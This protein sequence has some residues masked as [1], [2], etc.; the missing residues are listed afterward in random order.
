[1]PEL[2]TPLPSEWLDAFTL[3]GSFGPWIDVSSNLWYMPNPFGLPRFPRCMTLDTSISHS[4]E[5]V[6]KF[7]P[8]TALLECVNILLD[9]F[10]PVCIYIHPG[11]NLPFR[12]LSQILQVLPTTNHLNFLPYSAFHFQQHVKWPLALCLE[13]A[14]FCYSW[15]S[16]RSNHVV[17]FPYV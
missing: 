10:W 14:C 6:Y 13:S 1:M 17:L 7:Y 8:P 15:S 3:P 11:S 4:P 12:E 16:W 9:A 5:F 2:S